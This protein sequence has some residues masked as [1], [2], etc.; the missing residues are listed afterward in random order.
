MS[1]FRRLYKR[2]GLPV[3]VQSLGLIFREI[4]CGGW[5]FK[6]FLCGLRDFCF[7]CLIGFGG[8]L[9]L[10]GVCVGIWVECGE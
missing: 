8:F 2:S 9:F 3:K 10:R 6:F 1:G 5:F 4:F 7:V